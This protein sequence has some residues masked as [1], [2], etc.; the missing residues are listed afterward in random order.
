MQAA[1]TRSNF[2]HTT[3][4]S[5]NRRAAGIICN[6][7]CV[8]GPLWNSHARCRDGMFSHHDLLQGRG[9]LHT[10]PIYQLDETALWL[11]RGWFYNGIWKKLWRTV[12]TV[13][14]DSEEAREATRDRAPFPS[15]KVAFVAL[16][17]TFSLSFLDGAT[18]VPENEGGSWA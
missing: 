10:T 9:G 16:S 14:H 18:R 3:P 6:T 15:F 4:R 5:L 8:C 12:R 17:A 1:R 2:H 7:L 13:T 11:D